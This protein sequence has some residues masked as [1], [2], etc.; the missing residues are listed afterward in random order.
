MRSAQIALLRVTQIC[1]A[2]AHIRCRE[3]SAMRTYLDDDDDDEVERVGVWPSYFFVGAHDLVTRFF[4]ELIGAHAHIPSGAT[5]P[6][7]RDLVLG[8]MA[9][10]GQKRTG[11]DRRRR[12][13]IAIVLRALRKGLAAEFGAAP[14]ARSL[15]EVVSTE[16]HQQAVNAG[17]TALYAATQEFVNARVATAA[18][19]RKAEKAAEE[20]AA[21]AKVAQEAANLAYGYPPIPTAFR[22]TL[23]DVSTFHDRAANSSRE[24]WAKRLSASSSVREISRV[25]EHVFS[26]L[27]ALKNDAPNFAETIDV[28]ARELQLC[29]ANGGELRL[30]PLLLLGPPAAGKTWLAALL[31]AA[32]VPGSQAEI[33]SIPGVT[34]AFELAGSSCSWNNSQP[35]RVVRTFMRTRSASPMIVLDEVDKALTGNYPP[36]PVLLP[37]LEPADAARW[38]DE[39][40]D[41]DFDVSRALFVA[42][43]NSLE[44]IDSALLSR[45]RV[46]EVRAPQLDELP[47]VV[48]SLYRAVRGGLTKL[49]RHDR[50]AD[51]T[52]DVLCEAFI[53][54]RQTARL[55]RDALGVAA[56]R[57]PHVVDL[58]RQD[59]LTVLRHSAGRRLLVAVATST[60]R[61]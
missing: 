47:N 53:D 27:E 26:R 55:I 58:R 30:S 10:L 59:V 44:P 50:L 22:H 7:P 51:D 61:H 35:G 24:A 12:R 13:V 42:T 48:R 46:I 45:F 29:R 36:A 8:L 52:V 19:K 1:Y 40:F 60:S 25:D 14:N 5:P 34:A 49:P 15:H 57:D 11:G 6:L 38:R 39:F 37:L 28:V 41:M 31:G 54:A 32:L 2:S 17:K 43:A 9:T 3:V 33:I 4:E 23:F 20:A 56:T 18:E 21:A 16:A